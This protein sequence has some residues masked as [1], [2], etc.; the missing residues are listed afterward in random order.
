MR[1]TTADESG[2]RRATVPVLPI[3]L[4]TQTAP[5]PMPSAEGSRP[6]PTRPVIA[7]VRASTR[8]TVCSPAL[9]THT[10]PRPA[11]TPTGAEPTGIES[12]T[13]A[14]AESMATRRFGPRLGHRRRLAGGG[15]DQRAADQCDDTYGDE[16]LPAAPRRPGGFD[17]LGRGGGRERFV[18]RE[19]RGLELP[20]P[21]PGLDPDLL[22]Q[23]APR[24]LEDRE[25]IGLAAGAVV[26]EHEELGGTLAQG[27]GRSQLLELPDDLTRTPEC[28][29]RLDALLEAPQ[30]QLVEASDRLGGPSLDRQLAER[31]PAP[32]PEGGGEQLPGAPMIGVRERP[33]AVGREVLEAPVVERF[34]GDR[35]R[36]A[37][38]AGDDRLLPETLAQP[39]DEHL[40][41][42]GGGPGHLLPPQCVRDAS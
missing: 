21:R 9:A 10:D 4:P 37:A 31:R 41:R 34:I 33:R 30:A 24:P 22:H 28:E 29:V 27:L 13:R 40:D 35:E 12:T 17:E 20:E 3:A 36:V 19:D 42:L 25:R 14:V 39:R 1:A 26:R 5:S 18:L 15:P 32:Q 16:R 11:A 38:V 8:S 7:R 2:S 23:R 6:M